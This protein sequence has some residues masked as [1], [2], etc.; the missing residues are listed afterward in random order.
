MPETLFE[1][2]SRMARPMEPKP[3]PFCS[4]PLKVSNSNLASCPTQGCWMHERRLTVPID[5]PIQLTQWNMRVDP[6]KRRKP[7]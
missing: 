7:K 1:R 6:P 3:C 5:D 2:M 4:K